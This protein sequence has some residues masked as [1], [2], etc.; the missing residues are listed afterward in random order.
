MTPQDLAGPIANASYLSRGYVT[1]PT[2]NPL[3][4][5]KNVSVTVRS[6]ICSIAGYCCSTL[7]VTRLSMYVGNLASLRSIAVA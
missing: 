3:G 4:Q 2:R 5:N 1:I 6:S 7:P